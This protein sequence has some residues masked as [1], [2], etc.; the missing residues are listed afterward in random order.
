ML[1]ALPKTTQMAAGWGPKLGPADPILHHHFSQH[2]AVGFESYKL[3]HKSIQGVNNDLLKFKGLFI[4]KKKSGLPGLG[5]EIVPNIIHFCLKRYMK[6]ST[7]I[8][9]P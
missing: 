4:V 7:P 3:N 5:N 8:F 1:K 2:I 9:K 6:N